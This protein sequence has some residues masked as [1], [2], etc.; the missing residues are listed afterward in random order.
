MTIEPII[1][2][3][4]QLLIFVATAWV[5]VKYTISMNQTY[6]DIENFIVL[7]KSINEDLKN[8]IENLRSEINQKFSK[9]SQSKRTII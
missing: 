2:F 1:I 4:A 9:D 5:F 6:S 8:E 7:R 3:M